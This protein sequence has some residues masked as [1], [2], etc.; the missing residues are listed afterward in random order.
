MKQTDREKIQNAQ[1]RAVIDCHVK[2]CNNCKVEFTGRAKDDICPKCKKS[3]LIEEIKDFIY[4]L[5]SYQD[6]HLDYKESIKFNKQ[7][8]TIEYKLNKLI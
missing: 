7:L 1:R 8:K 3:A 4:M 5:A 2:P 6:E